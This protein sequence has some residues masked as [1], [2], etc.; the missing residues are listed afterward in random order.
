[1]FQFVYVRVHV[2]QQQKN[3]LITKYVLYDYHEKQESTRQLWI[4]FYLDLI[5]V[6]G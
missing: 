5:A 6:N 4:V 3:I 2:P 1:M